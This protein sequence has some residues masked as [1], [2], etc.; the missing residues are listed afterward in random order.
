MRIASLAGEEVAR[1]KLQRRFP[2]VWPHPPLSLLGIVTLLGLESAGARA[3]EDRVAYAYEIKAAYLFNFAKFVEWPPSPSRNAAEPFR[4]GVLGEDPFKDTL[5][6]LLRGK[7]IDRRPFEIRRSRKVEDL[8]GSHIL[9]ISA[10]EKDRVKEILGSISSLPI[11]TVAEME[12]FTGS[13]G[14]VKFYRQE[15]SIR[16]EINTDAVA[17]ARLK[18]SAKLLQVARLVR[19][20]GS[21]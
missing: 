9:F 7:L 12:G 5:D 4:I 20:E 15:A 8:K 21:P 19:E 17:R 2:G 6:R 1:V 14:A 3:Q 16:I 10:S 11:L 13:G 18:A